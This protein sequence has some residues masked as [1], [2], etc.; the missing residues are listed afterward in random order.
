M[1]RLQV[2]GWDDNAMVKEDYCPKCAQLRYEGPDSAEF[3]VAPTRGG[4]WHQ[5]AAALVRLLV[6]LGSGQTQAL[7]I[8][9]PDTADRYVQMLIGHGQAHPEASSNVY[10]EGESRL[11]AALEELL[12]LLG[13]W[14]PQSD[15]DVPDSMPATWT[16]ALARGDWLDLVEILLATIV[17]VFRF[18]EHVPVMVRSF[19]ADNPC[20]DCFPAV[21]L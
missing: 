10:L 11:S 21:P 8:K 12:F 1:R 6:R 3:A 19:M 20:R 16:L 7:I 2:S 18:D 4:G 5:W 17:G 15:V 9:Q 14:P 13:C